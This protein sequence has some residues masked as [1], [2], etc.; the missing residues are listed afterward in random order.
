MSV[1]FQYTP[2]AY[3]AGKTYT[4]IPNVDA[5]DLSLDRA[6]SA[7]RINEDGFI[8]VMGDNVPRMD[9]TDGGCPVLLT[10]PQAENLIEDSE[11]FSQS[12]WVESN[13]DKNTYTTQSPKGEDTMKSIS[14][15]SVLSSE[16]RI[17]ASFNLSTET[18]YSVSLYLK[19]FA[20]N[21]FF[22]F[23]DLTN[24]NSVIINVDSKSVTSNT[25][26]YDVIFY[27][28]LINNTYRVAIKFE[29]PASISNNLLDF[30]ITSN[31]TSF[32]SSVPIGDKLFL[33]GVQVEAGDKATSYIP[34][35]G[36]T[37]VRLADTGIETGD[38][39]QYIDSSNFT[40]EIECANLF[41]GSFALLKSSDT[42]NRVLVGFTSGGVF[43]NSFANGVKDIDY[44]N[45]TATDISIMNKYRI[46]SSGQNFEFFINDVSFFTG[47]SSISKEFNELQVGNGNDAS[48]FKGQTKSIKIS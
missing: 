11:D 39:S 43:F 23:R 7:T 27:E 47:T 40:L 30:G 32:N 9:Y 15:N 12:Y 26:S 5:A 4:E 3:K 38:I 42:S 29:T 21:G 34:T 10:E 35:D 46:D 20:N 44:F 6:S 37:A 18:V 22:Y 25:G 33:W 2:S 45:T 8:E 36:A 17:R 28:D 19:K 48:V 24:N 16:H 41:D 1:K 31:S 13:V 14:S